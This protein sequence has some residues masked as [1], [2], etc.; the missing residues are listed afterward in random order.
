VILDPFGSPEDDSDD[1]FE[2]YD[3]VVPRID[4]VAKSANGHSFVLMKSSAADGLMTPAAIRDLLAKSTPKTGSTMAAKKMFR[5]EQGWVTSPK[6]LTKSQLATALTKAKAKAKPQVAVFDSAGQLVGTCD[7]D[8]ITAIA[9]APQTDDQKAAAAATA[10]AAKVSAQ[11]NPT[12]ATAAAA[13]AAAAAD[14]GAQEIAKSMAG[15]TFR[16]DSSST[17]F[18]KSAGTV[19]DRFTALLKSVDARHS[20]QLQNAVA[21]AAL[22]L[23]AGGN[24]SSPRAVRMAKML[25]VDLAAGEVARQRTRR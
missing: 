19:D 12:P 16:G 4:L 22:R 20:T 17:N 1:F 23:V 14:Q 8:A 9:A 6:A 25:A 5:Y 7:A 15:A 2:A 13:P 11:M 18:T 10:N 3:A 24:A 21:V